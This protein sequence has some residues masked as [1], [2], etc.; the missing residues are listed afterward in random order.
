MIINISFFF[1]FLVKRRIENEEGVDFITVDVFPSAKTIFLSF[2][3]F[4][5]NACTNIYGFI[6]SY[7]KSMEM[8]R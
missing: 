3:G 5:S 6:I 8:L 4:A 7:T 1:F 2:Y